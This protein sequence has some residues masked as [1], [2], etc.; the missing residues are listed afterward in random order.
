VPVNTRYKYGIAEFCGP[1]E[2]L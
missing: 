2:C 1:N